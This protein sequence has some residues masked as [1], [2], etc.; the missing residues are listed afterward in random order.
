MTLSGST[1]A[2]G[3]TRSAIDESYEHLRHCLDAGEEKEIRQQSTDA[4]RRARTMN[5]KALR[6][7]QLIAER[8]SLSAAASD[9][10]LS[11]PAVSR[12]IAMLETELELRL[13]DRTGRGLIITREGQRFYERTKHILAGVEEIPG[14]AKTIRSGDHQFRV[15]TTPHIG[16]S[17]VSPALSI[18]R[19][20]NDRLHCS[21][22]L[23]SRHE[24]GE[25]IR[26]VH[27]DLMI[28]SLPLDASNAPIES[29]PLFKVLVE[30]VL[31]KGHPLASRD[32][33]TAADFTAET[34]IGSWR[35]AFW[36][37]QI[38]D[39]LPSSTLSP[40]RLVETYNP[41]MAYQL[42]SDGA[43]IAFLDRLC[44]RGLDTSRVAFC[45]VFP[46]TWI[47]FGYVYLSGKSPGPNVL[48]F[49]DAIRQTISDFRL[50]SRENENAVKLL[51]E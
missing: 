31:P 5:F 49:V 1:R 51:D 4:G 41:I 11:Q 33:L 19:S 48:R 22:D 47:T 14:I 20:E 15:L 23:R 50:Q 10:C 45:P 26:S 43:G 6:A 39:L 12:L 42:A 13:F 35:D 44:A 24:M 30:A 9:L 3:R 36:R 29:K 34:L 40:G 16:Q 25:A 27:F 28:A 37:Q 38:G 17:I 18:L 32:R 7:F 46:S 2:Q 21:I 8:G